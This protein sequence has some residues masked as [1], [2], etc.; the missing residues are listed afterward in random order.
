MI[1]CRVKPFSCFL[2]HF[3]LTAAA[4]P[5]LIFLLLDGVGGTSLDMRVRAWVDGL[6]LVEGGA[7]FERVRDY[8]FRAG[9]SGST[10]NRTAAR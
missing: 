4:W 1:T 10:K 3:V 5:V 9:A 2:Q 6:V 7:V 8:V